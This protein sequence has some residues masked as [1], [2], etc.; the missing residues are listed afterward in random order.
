MEEDSLCAPTAALI[1]QKVQLRQVIIT[2]SCFS[3]GFYSPC[4]IIMIII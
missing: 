4:F 3:G 1:E 2:T